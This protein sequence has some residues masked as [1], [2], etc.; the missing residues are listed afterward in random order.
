MVLCLAMIALTTSCGLKSLFKGEDAA[1]DTSVTTVQNGGDET[2]DEDDTTTTN[3]PQAETVP[4]VEHKGE[5]SDD[6]FIKG[7]WG[8]TSEN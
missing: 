4:N 3:K 1:E 8:D 5:M 7:T 6:D 2:P